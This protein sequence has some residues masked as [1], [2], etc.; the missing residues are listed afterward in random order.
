MSKYLEQFNK[1]IKKLVEKLL[2]NF[3]N[4]TNKTQ[5]YEDYVDSIINYINEHS[6]DYISRKNDVLNRFEGLKEKLELNNQNEKSQLLQNYLNRLKTIYEKK[7]P[8]QK[9]NLYSYINLVIRLAYSPLKTRVNIE[10]LKEQFENRY[11]SNQYGGY[12]I[13]KDYYDKVNQIEPANTVEIPE[14]D[15]NEKTPSISEDEEVEEENEKSKNDISE[16]KY[17]DKN[18]IMESENKNDNIIINNKKNDIIKLDFTYEGQL[19]KGLVNNILEYLYKSKSKL[20][21]DKD[22]FNK[23]PKIYFNY[24]LAANTR[25]SDNLIT[26]YEQVSSDFI[27]FRVLNLF[28]E[29]YKS[30]DASN[31]KENFMNQFFNI[32]TIDIPN[33]LLKDILSDV[34]KR[35]KQ[36]SYLRKI[37]VNFEKAGI[38]S[39]MSDKLV[40]LINQFLN[41]HD[42]V[43]TS[44]IKIFYIQK[45]Q[46]EKD[47]MDKIFINDSFK[48]NLNF[49]D[50]IIDYSNY[51]IYNEIIVNKNKFTLMRFM[52][53]YT[54]QFEPIIK[55]F[56]LILN[57]LFKIITKI[58]S[59]NKN[60]NCIVN[61]YIIDTLYYYSKSE[62]K[63]YSE[64]FIHLMD[65]YIKLIYEFILNGN[66][67]DIN[68]EFF[69]DNVN[70]KF[71]N[72][73]QKIKSIF[74][75]DQNYIINDWVNCFKIRS[76]SFDGKEMACVPIPFMIDDLH[77]K[78]LETGKTTFLLKNVKVI[79]FYS[80]LNR[81]VLNEREF[82]FVDKNTVSKKMET[83]DII[84]KKYINDL[85]EISNNLKIE[86]N[87][88]VITNH[89]INEYKFSRNGAPV[90]EFIA[91]FQN[92]NLKNI[93]KIIND[94]EIDFNDFGCFNEDLIDIN[95]K[96]KP[97]EKE[98]A[99]DNLISLTIPEKNDSNKEMKNIYKMTI[100]NILSNS[101]E[102][103]NKISPDS[104]I[105]NIDMVLH[106]LYINHILKINRVINAK[107]IDIL[108]SRTNIMKNFNLLFNI[109][110]F[111]AGFSMNNFI[112]E[113]NNYIYRK[114]ENENMLNIHNN[115]F[116]ENILYELASS[117]MSDLS[118]FK[119]E[120]YKNI[121]I[122]FVDS[123][124]SYLIISSED[125]LILKYKSELPASIFYNDKVMILYNRI[126]NYLVK[127][128][129]SFALIRNINLDKQL[130]KAENISE[131]KKIKLL[132]LY[133]IEYRS[134]ILNFANNL[135]LY[136]FHFV[137]EPFII[138]FKGKIDEVNS[139]DQFIYH[140]NKFLKDIAFF[141]GLSNQNYLN[142]L[143]DILNLIIGFPILMDRFFMLDL[144]DI[145]DEEK[146]K[147]YIDIFNNTENFKAKIDNINKHLNQMKEKLLNP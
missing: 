59:S 125:I 13:N 123:I 8:A 124:K 86:K 119:D 7:T 140:H 110:L 113:L 94:D 141:F 19:E 80:E 31:T 106:Y 74:F 84:K 98:K 18:I 26:K 109:C 91:D 51:Y 25:L 129:R 63:L 120:I 138:K 107:F 44:F 87:N 70:L 89:E 72:D 11:L 28:I 24:M 62:R 77:F 67:I 71:S 12:D 41:I 130:K 121:K 79:D 37:G 1:D 92:G 139:I 9:D 135:E 53:I 99:K 97:L 88:L 81:D 112:I 105:H 78:I 73:S 96:Q 14:V 46:I 115:F 27:L 54:E 30:D 145:E 52:N 55:Y 34:Y 64:I 136:L 42:N 103:V 45:G 143:Y 6:L 50:S 76:F 118:P 116:L 48:T 43:L 56:C 58:A 40:F 49:L 20:F 126:F 21:A 93:N 2:L 39:L 75:F 85:E 142:D 16:S 111:N 128:K 144:D 146:Q 32:N 38:Q 147:L 134:L 61:K 23:M 68:D 47:Y 33:N 104:N 36:I 10:Y 117:P 114:S 100:D 60:Q 137:V 5:N 66:L 131:N 127:I 122:S 29:E 15:Y 35:R 90:P 95:A 82:N 132:V 4:V 69:I 102:E 3:A 57:Y 101:K 17:D 133:L 108:I 22:Y 83:D 65:A